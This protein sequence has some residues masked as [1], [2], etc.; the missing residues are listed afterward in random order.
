MKNK[1]ILLSLFFLIGAC[2]DL[3]EEVFDEVQVADV[4][5]LL[6]NP[7]PEFLDNFVASAY[8][9]LIPNFTERN[10]FNLQESTTDLSMTPTRLWVDPSRSDWFDGGRYGA[11]HRHEWNASEQTVND[12]WGLLQGGIAACLEILTAFNTPESLNNAALAPR[13]AETQGLLAFY[14]WA[15]FDL[16]AQVPYT[17]IT[18][19][20]NTVLRG[21]DA[22]NE[23]DR[24]LNAAI[25]VLRGKDES[26]SGHLFSKAAAQTLLARLYLNKA[27]YADPLA[28]SYNFS[29]GDMNEVITVTT[30]IINNGGYALATDYFRLF[31]GDS[32]N[33]AATDELIFTVNCQAGQTC[34][35]AF[36]AM[37]MSQGQFAGDGGSFRG[38][39]GF[40]TLPEFVDSW[41]TSDPRYF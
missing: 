3:D 15:I 6:A 24:L 8:A 41:D 19:G 11:L 9:E 21:A 20:Q 26:Q 23:I 34:N 32:D 10:Y 1:I 30:D 38:W 18:N 16:Y 33:N 36:T 40:C 27:V 39:N 17:D 37:V 13:R 35:R 31:D 28:S 7:T 4:E 2:V 29:S 14:M 5:A 12:V 22:V 25:P